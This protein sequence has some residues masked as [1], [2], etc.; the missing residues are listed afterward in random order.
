[1][2]QADF[3]A[4]FSDDEKCA[5][6][7]TVDYTLEPSRVFFRKERFMAFVEAFNNL[8]Y[9]EQDVVSSHLGLCTECFRLTEPKMK[10]YNIAINNEL[11]SA[12]AVENIYHKAIKKLQDAIRKV[13][14]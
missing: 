4:I 3:Y 13:E 12:E 6:D 10:F 5:E 8:G 1:M 9:R 14:N 2:K 7:V 11:S